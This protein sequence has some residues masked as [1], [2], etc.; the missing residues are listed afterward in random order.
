[1]RPTQALVKLEVSYGNR[2]RI[3]PGMCQTSLIGN[4]AGIITF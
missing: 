1:M 4:P 3:G 2:Y